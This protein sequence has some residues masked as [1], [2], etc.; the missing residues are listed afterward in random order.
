MALINP[1]SGGHASPPNSAGSVD[2]LNSGF[3]AIQFK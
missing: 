2:V 3:R 1:V